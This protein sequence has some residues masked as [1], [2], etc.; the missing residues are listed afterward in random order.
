MGACD[1][2]AKAAKPGGKGLTPEQELTEFHK[3]VAEKLIQKHS[4]H[5][6]KEAFVNLGGGDDDKVERAEMIGKLKSLQYP[7][8]PDFLFDLLDTDNE[9]FITK[10]EFTASTKKDYLETGPLRDFSR[11]VNVTY[12]SVDDA[13]KD[14]DAGDGKDKGKGGHD[15][16]LSA[17]EFSAMLAKMKYKGDAS[18]VYKLPYT[19]QSGSVTVNEF[20]NRLHKKK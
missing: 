20:K 2:C 11:F 16:K 4:K 7:G 3:F 13:F 9:G 14:M 1:S 12:G 15:A 6:L 19:D 8:N 17:D 5:G 18:V 10:T